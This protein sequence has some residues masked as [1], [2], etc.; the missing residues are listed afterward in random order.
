MA[1]GRAVGVGRVAEIPRMLAMVQDHF[2]VEIAQ[3][4]VV[5]GRVI[6]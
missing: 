1:M 6:A 3:I 4:V 2:L 5:M